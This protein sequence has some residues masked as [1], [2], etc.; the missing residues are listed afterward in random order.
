MFR[1]G[2]AFVGTSRVIPRFRQYAPGLD[3]DASV[4][5]VHAVDVRSGDVVG[6]LT[7]PDGNQIF[8]VEWLPVSMTRGF[9]FL[10]GRRA[11]ASASRA[12]FYSF[13]NGADPPSALEAR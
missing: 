5:G 1:G 7:W 13:T 9:P 3:V 11:A 6:S 2:Y 12:L 10:A 8:S 4:C